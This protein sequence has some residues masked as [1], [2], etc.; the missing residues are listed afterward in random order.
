MANIGKLLRAPDEFRDYLAN[1]RPLL[2]DELMPCPRCGA[3]D[4]PGVKPT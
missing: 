1:R 3:N 4:E 2:K